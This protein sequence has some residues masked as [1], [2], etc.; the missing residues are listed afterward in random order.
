M[1]SSDSDEGYVCEACEKSFETE[2]GLTRHVRDIGL[3]G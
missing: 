2:Q 3:V 1:I